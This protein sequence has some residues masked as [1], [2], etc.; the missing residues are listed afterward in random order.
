MSYNEGLSKNKGCGFFFVIVQKICRLLD[1]NSTE[2][3][4]MLQ[5][6]L[7]YAILLHK[8]NSSGILE[9]IVGGKTNIYKWNYILTFVSEIR[10]HALVRL[11]VHWGCG[12]RW[13]RS[14]RE[15]NPVFDWLTRI[16]RYR[17]H[18]F[19]RC[20][21]RHGYWYSL[22]LIQNP[23]CLSTFYKIP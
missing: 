1:K 18:Y 20:D 22:C 13:I 16:Y 21:A 9:E 8:L 6:M 7:K 23:W 15:D 10:R 17:D 11:G 19:C 4:G 2:P 3:R 12:S 5:T 14:S